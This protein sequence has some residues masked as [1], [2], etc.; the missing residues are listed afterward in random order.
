MKDPALASLVAPPAQC[1]FLPFCEWLNELI[2]PLLLVEEFTVPDLTFL[3]T[4]QLNAHL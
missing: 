1:R 4:I 2:K 3:T